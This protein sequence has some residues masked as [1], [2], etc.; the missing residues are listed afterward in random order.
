M[1]YHAYKVEVSGEL[2]SYDRCSLRELVWV[3]DYFV[4]SLIQL[5]IYE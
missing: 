5:R 1:T 4:S 2:S 3:I